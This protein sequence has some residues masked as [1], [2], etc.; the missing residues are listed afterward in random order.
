MTTIFENQEIKDIIQLL[1]CGFGEDFDITKLKY[2][3]VIIATDADEDGKHIALLLLTFFYRFMPDLIRSGHIYYAMGP[4]FKITHGDNHTYVNSE[5]ERDKVIKG[6]KGKYM[7]TRFKGL[8]ELAPKDL[9][10]TMVNPKTRTLM[11]YT[12][13]DETE[14][15]ETFSKLMGVDTAPRKQFLET[16]TL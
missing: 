1:G 10:E 12:I 7:V 2:D 3:K 14:V 8:G 5:A 4:L 15:N 9:A 11:Q 16:G 6:L 13:E